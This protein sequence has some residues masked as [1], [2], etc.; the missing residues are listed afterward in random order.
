MLSGLG[1]RVDSEQTDCPST[2]KPSWLLSLTADISLGFQ[3]IDGS[4][5]KI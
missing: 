3:G 4:D 2:K 5:L 1:A